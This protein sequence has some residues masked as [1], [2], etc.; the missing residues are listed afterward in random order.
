MIKL[1]VEILYKGS[2]F[3]PTWVHSVFY[4]FSSTG[5]EAFLLV[6]LRR[7]F[8]MMGA[9]LRVSKYALSHARRSLNYILK[10]IPIQHYLALFQC[11]LRYTQGMSS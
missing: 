8:V 7:N 9:R 3:A 4:V 1:F 11:T 5:T 6:M 2:G 10:T